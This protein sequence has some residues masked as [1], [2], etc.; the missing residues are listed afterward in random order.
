[1][2]FRRRASA[3]I[4]RDNHIL[5]VKISDQAKSWWCLPGGTIELGETPEQTLT[6]ELREE[7][8]L[9]TKPG[10]HL[11]EATLPDEDGVDYGILVDPPLNLPTLGIDPLVTKWAWF[12]MNEEN[13]WWQIKAV[14]QALTDR[15]CQ[16]NEKADRF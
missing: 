13:D 2:V 11:Y 1:M 6:R 7:L 10:Q 15:N 4:I 16:T 5:M 14:R 8:N 12:P 9:N 3:V